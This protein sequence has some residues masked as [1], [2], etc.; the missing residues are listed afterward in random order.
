MAKANIQTQIKRVTPTQAKKY[1]ENNPMNRVINEASVDLLAETIR[2]GRWKLNGESIKIAPDGTL[3]DGQHRLKAIVR[4]DTAV[5][6]LV[7]T[8]LSK[9]VF[10]TLDT[11]KSRNAA[12][13]LSISGYPNP[14][15]VA[16][17]TSN[18]IT[19]C[20]AP[21]KG[22]QSTKT[23]TAPF[24]V[25]ERFE[26]NPR[27]AQVTSQYY[28]LQK[29]AKPGW[30]TAF[31]Y[32]VSEFEPV[33]A[34][35]F[36][37]MIITGAGMP[38]GHPCLLLRDKLLYFKTNKQA[39]STVNYEWR[40]YVAAW[41]AFHKGQLLTRLAPRSEGPIPPIRGIDASLFVSTFTA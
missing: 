17:I 11:G 5:Q 31:Y 9:D 30:L 37:N 41:N 39:S 1:L 33:K 19:Y 10:E 35:E 21:E 15:A 16:T 40:L 32:V 20:A 23:R 25:L 4:A 36:I 12:D 24:T 6:T 28:R 3:L 14:H 13:V 26:S 18:L 29:V 8:G 22:A 34:N 7:V 27:I 2:Q 38:V